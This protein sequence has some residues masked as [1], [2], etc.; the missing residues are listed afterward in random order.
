[1]T[2]E[3]TTEETPLADD[4]RERLLNDLSE[5]FGEILVESHLRPHEDVWFRVKIEAWQDAAMVAKGAGFE[6]FGFLS[7]IDWHIAPEGRYEDTEFDAG[8]GQEED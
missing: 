8:K 6:Y 2:D 1:M 4:K 3:T 7:A 5:S